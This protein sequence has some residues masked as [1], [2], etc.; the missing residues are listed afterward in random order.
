VTRCLSLL[1]APPSFLL[2][3]IKSARSVTGAESPLLEPDNT[4]CVNVDVVQD[5][6]LKCLD[7]KKRLL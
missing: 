6:P 5:N 4:L 7:M 3:R 1:P 2:L